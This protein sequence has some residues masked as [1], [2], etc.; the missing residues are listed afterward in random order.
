M[1]NLKTSVDYLCNE[2]QLDALFIL[3]LFHHQPPHVLDIPTAHHQEVYTIYV[4]VYIQ[5][6]PPDD[7][8]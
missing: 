4:P 5:C 3:H 7:R 6:I 8:Q 1:L 2:N